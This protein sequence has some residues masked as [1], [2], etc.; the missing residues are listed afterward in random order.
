MTNSIAPVLVAY[1]SVHGSTEQLAREIAL[2]VEN[3]GLTVKLRKI[4]RL[5]GPSLTAEDISSE[6]VSVD[7]LSACSGL[8]LGSPTRFGTM[9]AA[10]KY[11][12]EQSAQQWIKG[13]L[14]DKPACVFSSSA[15]LHGGQ[16][17]TLLSM[18]TPLLHQGMLIMGLSYAEPELHTTM[19]GGTPYG[20]T[21]HA[22][23]DT[24]RLSAEERQ[25]AR[26]QGQRLAQMIKKMAD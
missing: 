25:L 12:L 11:F 26:K 14:I 19:S 1:Y 7:D 3:E 18:I 22:K 5:D 4:P 9:A 15:S 24:I 23:N 10:V 8:A 2:G 20:V 17:N 13:E 16:E 6:Y 21:H